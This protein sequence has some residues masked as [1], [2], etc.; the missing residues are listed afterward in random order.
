M[1]IK[2]T[3]RLLDY[4]HISSC[5]TLNKLNESHSFMLT[6]DFK[7]REK[8]FCDTTYTTYLLD[9]FKMGP[10][11]K[12]SYKAKFFVFKLLVVR[13]RLHSP[14]GSSSVCWRI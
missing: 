10:E 7:H 4:L 6:T 3:V 14:R 9:P 1:F 2:G 8:R 13:L 5:K 11:V 12:C